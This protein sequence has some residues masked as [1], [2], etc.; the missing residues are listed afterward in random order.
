MATIGP[1][2]GHAVGDVVLDP[3]S[4]FAYVI[5]LRQ[6]KSPTSQ[7]SRGVR[8]VWNPAQRL[9]GCSSTEILALK[10]ARR[11]NIHQSVAKHSFSFVE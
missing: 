3:W 7:L 1:E 6:S 11:D 2:L 5:E 10:V 4:V 8:E 9:V